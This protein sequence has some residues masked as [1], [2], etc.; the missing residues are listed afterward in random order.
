ME[1]DVEK[2]N[3]HANFPLVFHLPAT[4]HKINHQNAGETYAPTALEKAIAVVVDAITAVAPLAAVASSAIKVYLTMA[5][6]V[7]ERRPENATAASIAVAT[8]S[9]FGD[10]GINQKKVTSLLSNY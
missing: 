6:A 7:Q 1:V 8:N 5:S 2:K 9:T 3:S 4:V 10:L